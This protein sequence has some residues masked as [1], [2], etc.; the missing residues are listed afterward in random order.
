MIYSDGRTPEPQQGKMSRS[1]LY[2][3]YWFVLN[4]I[5]CEKRK[6]NKKRKEKCKPTTAPPSPSIF[7]YRFSLIH[8]AE[9]E[10]LFN[11]VGADDEYNRTH[12]KSF[13]LFF[14]LVQ[15]SYVA[16]TVPGFITTSILY[17]EPVSSLMVRLWPNRVPST[18]KKTGPSLG[19]MRS[20]MEMLMMAGTPSM[21]TW[22]S[23]SLSK[24]GFRVVLVRNAGQGKGGA[25][26][27]GM[28]RTP[29]C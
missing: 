6:K 8:G 9:V 12:L 18:L 27:G 3:Y 4:V 19:W 16:S 24:L 11:T 25:G 7:L 29:R 10:H 15:F 28:Q 2:Y 23:I 17:L 14:L 1:L 21:F 13:D 26:G 22:L 20:E 5:I